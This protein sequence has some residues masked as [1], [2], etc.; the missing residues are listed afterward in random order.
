[1]SQ[2][3]T[4]CQKISKTLRRLID[5]RRILGLFGKECRLNIGRNIGLF[6]PEN[7]KRIVLTTDDGAS[8]LEALTDL[9]LVSGLDGLL[10]GGFCGDGAALVL[11]DR[12]DGGDRRAGGHTRVGD[13]GRGVGGAGR[14]LLTRC[15]SFE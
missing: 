10:G 11:N 12:V 4:I 13:D 6:W 8:S 15:H 7:L 1:M 5:P 14:L 2:S 3:Q 9:T